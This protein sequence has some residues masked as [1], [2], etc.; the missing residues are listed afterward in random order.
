MPKSLTA[1]LTLLGAGLFLRA[2]TL[3]AQAGRPATPRTLE[4]A[5]LLDW[6]RVGDPRP[7]PDGAVVGEYEPASRHRTERIPTHE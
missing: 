7:S 1:F 3:P 4:V 6:E 5:D 2:G